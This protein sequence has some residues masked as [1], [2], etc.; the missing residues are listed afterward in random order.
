MAMS[1]VYTNFCGMIVSETRGGVERD[2]VPDTLDSTAALVDST[3]TITDRWEYWPYGEVALRSGSSPTPFTFVGT[4]G[5]FRDLLDMLIYVRARYYRPQLAKWQTVDLLRPQQSA[6]AY[7]HNAPVAE[8]DPTGM[9]SMREIFCCLGKALEN[10][11]LGCLAGVIGACAV[12]VYGALTGCA[13]N[14]ATCGIALAVCAHFLCGQGV[15]ACVATGVIGA[16]GSLLGCL[17]NGDCAPKPDPA[18]APGSLDDCLSFCGKAHPRGRARYECMRRCRGLEPP[19]P[20]PVPKPQACAT[21]SP[22]WA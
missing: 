2:Y 14:P 16:L 12:C 19:R 1:A 4:L 7:G 6:Y 22:T 15:I 13:A 18:P 10:T 3:Q 20:S 8:V 11:L 17:R 9:L 5:Y 21:E